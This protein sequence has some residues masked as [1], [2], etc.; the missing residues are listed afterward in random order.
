MKRILSL[1]F[2]LV[3]GVIEVMMLG[4]SGPMVSGNMPYFVGTRGPVDPPDCV[5]DLTIH[6]TSNPSNIVYGQSSV[7]SW[8]VSMPSKCVSF[9]VRLNGKVVAPAGSQTFAPSRST[10]YN[11]TVS[12]SIKG[13]QGS[14]TNSTGVTVSYLPHILID[15]DTLDP[16]G[17]LVGALQFSTN[18]TQTIELC[19]VDL[20][21]TGYSNLH[22]IDNRSLIAS[23]A[24][25]RGPRNLGPRIFVTDKRGEEPL[26]LIEGDNVIISGFRLE[27]PTSNI[28]SDDNLLESGILI[29]P[30]PRSDPIH[31]IEI[32][33][34]EIFHW[35]NAG[36]EVR[37]NIDLA[38][39]GR[40]FDTNPNAV[41]IQRNF[42]HHNRHTGEGYGVS[43]TK[44]AYALI[45]QNVF[46][47]NRH[48]IAGGRPY[49]NSADYS[50]YTARDN[51]ILPG[52]VPSCLLFICT[53]THQI[54][55]HG[56]Q[57]EWYNG[58]NWACG[59]AGE[60]IMIE[61]NTILYSD[62][63][64]IKIRGNP[65][66]KGVVDSNVFVHESPDDAIAQNGDCGYGDNISNPI[67]VRPNN[68]FGANPMA[69][70]GS[71]DFFGDGQVDQFMTTGVA[72]W[73]KS[74]VTNQWRYLNTMP[75]LLSQ[76][77]L[78]R[79][80]G[81]AVCDVAPKTS[82]PIVIIKK[83]SS[84]GTGPWEPWGVVAPH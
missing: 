41:R 5:D 16:V 72:W 44:G 78:G 74:P 29:D 26:F 71:C 50:G 36:V 46:D 32:S 7:V 34:M 40:L 21:L 20:D 38:E 58:T 69:E 30:F 52:G 25:A 35:S 64:A 15:Q 19:N 4:F 6:V 1:V 13:V 10:T 51:L 47:E 75:E 45:E 60:T 59:T 61:R 9:S 37:D 27:G 65:A 53:H 18:S 22:L 54:D 79:I 56:D 57:N 80:D 42:F 73:A 81:D 24:C 63:L 77:Q 70:L 17:V 2:C 8:S 28:E 48:A 12:Y 39:R 33:N 68:I 3:I 43:V 76:L 55:M 66:N 14:Q 84:G 31:N 67:D 83:Y 62:G 82:S 23:P 49:E 11:V